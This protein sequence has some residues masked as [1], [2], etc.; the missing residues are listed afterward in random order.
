MVGACAVRGAGLH[1]DITQQA[2][3]QGRVL[4]RLHM[5]H[6]RIVTLCSSTCAVTSNCQTDDR[7]ARMDDSLRTVC[8]QSHLQVAQCCL[9]K[10]VH[11]HKGPLAVMSLKKL[12]ALLLQVH[13]GGRQPGKLSVNP[14]RHGRGSVVVEKQENVEGSRKE[15]GGRRRRR[16][17]LGGVTGGRK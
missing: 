13:V 9:D 2:V 15:E 6:H 14:T 7:G 12:I 11:N 10:V 8:Q 3:L 16:V 4:Q 1:A 5:R 17:C